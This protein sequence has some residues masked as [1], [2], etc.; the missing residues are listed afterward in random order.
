MSLL[1]LDRSQKSVSPECTEPLNLF[2]LKSNIYKDLQ[3]CLVP[4]KQIYYVTI[5]KSAIVEFF[6]PTSLQ[7][8]IKNNT[9]MS[10]Q[11]FF[12]VVWLQH[13]FQIKDLTK[14][15]D[16]MKFVCQKKYGR[17]RFAQI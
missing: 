10:H 4:H 6:M 15:F 17:E 16:I 9:E 12:L 1:G 5:H 13:M 14:K 2:S 8:K 3:Y 11:C 7:K